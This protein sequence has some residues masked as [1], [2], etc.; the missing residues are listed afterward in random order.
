MTFDQNTTDI[1][2]P[3]RELTGYADTRKDKSAPTKTPPLPTTHPQGIL[4]VDKQVGSTS[5]RLVS[6]LRK[7][8]GIR[9][10]GHAG[11]LDP[12]ATGLMVMLVGQKFTKLSDQFL[13]SNK[14][15]LASIHLGVTTDSYDCDGVITSTSDIIPNLDEVTAVIDKFQ[16]EIEQT[17]PM[18]S[19]KKVQGQKLYELARKGIVI[20]RAKAKVNVQ[21]QLLAYEY[22]KIDILVDCS[23]GTYIRSL[24]YDI[25]LALGCGAHLSSLT[26]TKSGSFSLDECIAESELRNPHFDISPFL[27]T[28]I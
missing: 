16:G 25:G 1:N 21:I 19:A 9:K 17:P 3:L 15:Y 11:T 12:F 24:A 14:Q 7:L 6:L 4:L 2:S 5:F 20:E 26:R 13:T 10:I 27:K 18:F 23:K 28:N 8:T 22:P